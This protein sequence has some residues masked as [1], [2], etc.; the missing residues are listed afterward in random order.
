MKS[1]DYYL[2]PFTTGAMIV[3]AVY[4][5]IQDFVGAEA[6]AEHVRNHW[7]TGYITV[8]LA[9][10]FLIWGL[11]SYHHYRTQESAA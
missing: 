11:V 2:D 9:I 4:S 5:L 10:V 7:V 1:K 6:W 3:M 8:P